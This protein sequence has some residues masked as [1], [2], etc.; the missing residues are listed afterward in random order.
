M[1]GLGVLACV[2]ACAAPFVF[3]LLGLGTGI[4]AL[5]PQ[6]ERLAMSVVVGGAVLIGV[7]LWRRRGGRAGGATCDD[8]CA[9]AP[10]PIAGGGPQPSP[11]A[12]PHAPPVNEPIAC[13]L[14]GKG[15]RKRLEEFRAAFGRGFIAG[16]R[17][18]GGFRWRFRLLPGFE[19]DLRALADREQECCRFFTFDLFAANQ[20]Q[21]IWW[22]VRANVDA[23][24]VLEEFFALPEQLGLT[25][26]ID[27]AAVQH[28]T[29]TAFRRA[30]NPQKPD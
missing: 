18:P 16:E 4:V 27:L 2:L 20:G 3:G 24:P 25:S 19:S 6:A 23:A 9:C 29:E 22:E 14:D 17:I 5:A 21:E 26:A 13:T 10:Q 7:G 8:S 1:V 15:M 28:S 12:S 11:V 30:G